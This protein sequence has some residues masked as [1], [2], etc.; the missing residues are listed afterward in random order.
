MS[1]WE[2]ATK[3]IVA[4]KHVKVTLPISAEIRRAPAPVGHPR[5]RDLQNPCMHYATPSR[6]AV[7]PR[8]LTCRGRLKKGDVEV[9][10]QPCRE[11]AIAYMSSKLARLTGNAV[12]VPL[13]RAGA[14]TLKGV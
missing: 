7:R 6:G 12:G 3:L 14:A 8:C 1:V 2:Q 9:C 10:S 5:V 4:G 11:K 13:T